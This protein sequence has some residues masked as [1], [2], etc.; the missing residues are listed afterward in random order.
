MRKFLRFSVLSLLLLV[1]NML[2]AQDEQ[3][4][5]FDFS[6][7]EGCNFPA[8]PTA[9]TTPFVMD[10]YT[11]TPEAGKFSY[12][13]YEGEN[14]GCVRFEKIKIKLPA[15]EGKVMKVEFFSGAKTPSSAMVQVGAMVDDKLSVCARK[16]IPSKGGSCSISTSKYAETASAFYI[17]TANV[18]QVR[19]IKVYL[20]VPTGIKE[21][22][23]S[24]AKDDVYYTL[25]GVR[26]A[27]PQKG[28]FIK[29][30]KKVVLK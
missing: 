16:Q 24:D 22:E 7:N 6:N 19:T 9:L 18:I 13:A 26:V 11:F 1:G 14:D 23:A 2:Y 4:V 12:I 10:G 15:F 21:V 8:E 20:S 5:T 25:T 30:G 27:H 3:V 29:N 28:I 17:S